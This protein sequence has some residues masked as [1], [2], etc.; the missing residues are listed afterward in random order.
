MSGKTALGSV[1]GRLWPPCSF[2]LH[3]LAVLGAG[4]AANRVKKSKSGW[5]PGVIVEREGRKSEN[6]SLVMDG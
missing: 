3:L 4:L 2:P 5:F 1:S 6:N